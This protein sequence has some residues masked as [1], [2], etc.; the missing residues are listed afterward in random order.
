MFLS[1]VFIEIL[2]TKIMNEY[3]QSDINQQHSSFFYLSLLFLC[4]L[5]PVYDSTPTFYSWS[6]RYLISRAMN[7]NNY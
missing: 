4:N 6:I 2:I 3:Q 7:K 5:E 1:S